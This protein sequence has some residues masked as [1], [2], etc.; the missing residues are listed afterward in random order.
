MAKW[1]FQVVATD[2]EWPPLDY[3]EEELNPISAAVVAAA[4]RTED[5]V[6][7]AC[8][9]ADGVLVEYSPFTTRVMDALPRLKIISEYGIGVDNIDVD[10]ATRRGICVAYVPDYCVDE[11]SDHAF[12]LILACGRQIVRMRRAVR[13]HLWSFEVAKPLFR[14]RDQTLGIVAFGK[15]AKAL[16]AKGK[17]YGFRVLVYDPYV[18]SQIL[19]G[20]GFCP[21]SLEQIISEADFVSLHAP[22]TEETRHLIGT[23]ELRAMKPTAYLINTS[24]G[25][26]VNEQA[27]YQAL[28]ER[29]IAGAGLDVLGQEPPDWESPLLALDNVILTPHAAFYSEK[30]LEDVRRGASREVARVLQGQWPLNMVNAVLRNRMPAPGRLAI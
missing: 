10:A 19:Q 21:A 29:W 27:L 8:G 20:Q 26:L 23:P 30:A 5:E 12:A 6:I 28:K 1:S 11:V 2:P 15:I 7:A 3:E 9:E 17:A 4:C 18:P 13:S 16:A 24:R 22:L 14:L 25:G